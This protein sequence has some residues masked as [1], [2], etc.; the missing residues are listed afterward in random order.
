MVISK[1]VDCFF[2]SGRK[3]NQHYRKQGYY[4][5]KPGL[6][7]NTPKHFIRYFDIL[8]NTFTV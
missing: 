6:T 5:F 2:S 8:M 7:H 4:F 1:F 3:S